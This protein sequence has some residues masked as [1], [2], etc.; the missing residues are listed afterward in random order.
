MPVSSVQLHH[1]TI[2][3]PLKSTSLGAGL[4]DADALRAM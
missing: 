1:S 3:L 2:I 4:V